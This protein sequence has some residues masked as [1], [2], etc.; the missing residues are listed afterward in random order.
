MGSKPVVTTA[1]CRI[2]QVTGSMIHSATRRDADDEKAKVVAWVLREVWLRRRG[3]GLISKR[4]EVINLYVQSSGCG[5]DMSRRRHICVR[6]ID[7]LVS[8][9]R[10][11]IF[12]FSPAAGGR[13]LLA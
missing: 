10:W 7:L 6:F 3:T 12:S 2:Y 9:P 5:A 1:N 4:V 13:L 11:Y 8:L